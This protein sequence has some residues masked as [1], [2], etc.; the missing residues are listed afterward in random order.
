MKPI[1]ISAGILIA[2]L[3]FASAETKSGLT[4]SVTIAGKKISIAYSA[5]A[6]NGRTGKLFGKDGLIGSDQG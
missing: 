1:W 6:V 3:S 5:P 2:A 4:E